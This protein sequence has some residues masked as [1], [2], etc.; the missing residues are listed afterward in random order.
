MITILTSRRLPPELVSQILDAAEYWPVCRRLT[1]KLLTVE[2]SVKSL[3]DAPGAWRNGQEDELRAEREVEGSG[4]EDKKGEFWYLVSPPIGCD[5]RELR[6]E[7]SANTM[8]VVEEED[9]DMNVEDK[10][11]NAWLVKVV[12]E[13]LSMDQGWSDNHAA[14]YGQ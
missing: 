9:D 2:D 13:T 14:L 8:A 6:D 11:K 1:R 10:G 3:R 5:G 7:I 4:L 12:L